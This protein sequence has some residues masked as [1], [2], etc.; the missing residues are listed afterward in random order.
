MKVRYALIPMILAGLLG[1][2]GRGFGG[3]GSLTP[4]TPAEAIQNE[5]N[6]LTRYFGLSST[7]AG[8]VTTILT[9]EQ[10]CLS[11]QSA[12]QQTARA[13]LVTAIK[14]GSTSSIST[15]IGNLTSLQAT[16]ETCRA[17]AEA[18]IYADLNST[19]QAKLGSGL[20]PL[21]GGGGAGPRAH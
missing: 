7:Q 15:A 18:G 21:G 2:Q 6:R 17:T 9:T 20:G 14:S 13:A 10:T 8:E 11:G 1:A 5:V 12:A 16:G 4:S 19:Q 3:G